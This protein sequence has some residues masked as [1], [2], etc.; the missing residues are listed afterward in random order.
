MQEK[1]IKQM[2]TY[3]NWWKR[4][5]TDESVYYEKVR[6]MDKSVKIG[7]ICIKIDKNG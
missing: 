3:K 5:K 6:K 4:I 1:R 2:K 7:G